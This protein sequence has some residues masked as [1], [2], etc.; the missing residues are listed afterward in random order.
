[1]KN[2]IK[3]AMLTGIVA[4]TVLQS[5]K[6]KDTSNAVSGDAGVKAYVAPGKV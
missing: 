4:A 2:I 5:C 6:P 1:M 3:T